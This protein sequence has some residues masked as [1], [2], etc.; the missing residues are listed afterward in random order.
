MVH[1]RG[2]VDLIRLAIDIDGACG[3]QASEREV[4]LCMTHA[5]RFLAYSVWA[6]DSWA[7][8]TGPMHSSDFTDRFWVRLRVSSQPRRRHHFPNC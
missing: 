8:D 4:L 7:F 1:P 5:F 2:A 3:R 6:L